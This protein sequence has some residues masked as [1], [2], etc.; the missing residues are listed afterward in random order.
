M[1]MLGLSSH[2]EY[3]RLHFS[4]SDNELHHL[5]IMEELGGNSSLLDCLLSQS[6]A[7][8]YY[9]VVVFLYL[10]SPSTAY[11]LNQHIEEHAYDTYDD[12]LK[13]NADML[14]QE[15]APICAH[16][17]Y[18]NSKLYPLNELKGTNMDIDP[19]RPKVETLYDVFCCIRDDEGRHAKVHQCAE[20]RH[21]FSI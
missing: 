11:N 5:K 21:C 12:F 3:M 6:I 13:K 8:S 17:Y 18:S 20:C 1:E 15:P 2:A 19:A 16:Q 4:E 14:A 9:W 10:L 7:F